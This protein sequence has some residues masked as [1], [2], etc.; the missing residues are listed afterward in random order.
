[1]T[2]KQK[3]II[4]SALPYVNNVLHLGNIIGSVLSADV[5]ARYMKLYH[6]E[7]DTIFVG[8]VDEYGTATEM[9]ARE[10]G[11]SCKELCDKNNVLHSEINKWFQIDFDAYGRTSQPNGEPEI[12]DDSWPQTQITHQIFKSLCTAGYVIEK[13]DPVLFC[14]QINA[15]VA[16][17]FVIGICPVC[18]YDRCSGDQCDQCQKLISPDEI[19]EPKYK[20][21]PSYRLEL[22][23]THNLYIDTNKVW[24]EKNMTQWFESQKSQW[25]DT[26]TG[27]TQAWLDMGLK[28]RSITRDLKWGTRVPDTPEFGSKYKDKV[29]YVWFDAPIGYISI[30]ESVL[31]KEKSE[32]FWKSDK[33]KLVQFMAKDNVQFHSVIFPVTLRGSGYSSITDVNISAIEYLMYEGQK[34]SKTNNIGLFADNVIEISKKY[35]ISSDLFRAYLISIRP[36]TSDSNFVLNGDNGFVDFV[37]NVLVKN[38]GNL[39]HRILSVA[40]QIRINHNINLIIP[41]DSEKLLLLYNSKEHQ[42]ILAEYH[43]YMNVCKLRE[44]FSSVLKYSSHIN[45]YVN[46]TAIWKLVKDE[47]CKD[48]LYLYFNVICKKIIT[49]S[50]ILRPFMPSI[51]L[52]IDN[53]YNMAVVLPYEK[54]TVM[55]KQLEKINENL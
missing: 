21:N 14:S 9:K 29:F 43:K 25:T 1:M 52:E 5:Y 44:G 39:I 51:S 37:N 19:I 20:P 2:D 33:T 32:S 35:N 4:T 31:G 55:I 36:E 45:K 28:P 12:I 42:D 26:A 30:S 3:L 50:N 47:K 13:E 22:R 54:P 18:K 38:I 48:D 15:Y 27:I 11:I 41:D 46:E 6:P 40:Y 16:D 17:R 24:Q 34:F 49:L 7:Y 53:K 23:F 10:L 8:G